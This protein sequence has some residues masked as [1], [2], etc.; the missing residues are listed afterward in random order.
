MTDEPGL[1]AALESVIRL[2][3]PI[4]HS[5]DVEQ[6]GMQAGVAIE[7]ARA[8][9]AATP[10]ASDPRGPECICESEFPATCGPECE[11]WHH[12]AASDALREARATIEAMSGDAADLTDLM[13]E[14]AAL[15]KTLAHVL[16]RTHD[17]G[18]G[19]CDAARALLNAEHELPSRAATPAASDPPPGEFLRPEFLDAIPPGR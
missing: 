1:R 7:T 18:C 5:I 3:E 17:S 2:L 8:A 19:T 11:C 6:A 16:V 13:D 4:P 14:A 12:A 15:R 9:L 10:A